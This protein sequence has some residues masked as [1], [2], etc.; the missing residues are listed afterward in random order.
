MDERGVPAQATGVELRPLR[1][2]VRNEAGFRPRRIQISAGAITTRV[3]HARAFGGAR[4]R[5]DRSDLRPPYR[6][7]NPGWTV[8]WKNPAAAWAERKV[9]CRGDCGWLC[10]TR[11]SLEGTGDRVAGRSDVEGQDVLSQRARAP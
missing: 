8:R 3:A 9:S 5:A 10:R 7:T 4:S 1:K 6:G 11:A 2:V